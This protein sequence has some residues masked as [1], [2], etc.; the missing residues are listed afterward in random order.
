MNV[1][2][3][4]IYENHPDQHFDTGISAHAFVEMESQFLAGIIKLVRVEMDPD[5]SSVVAAYKDGMEVSICEEE[6]EV[7][8]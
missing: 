3:V 2:Y 1:S 8:S 4:A 5:S 7:L 6:S